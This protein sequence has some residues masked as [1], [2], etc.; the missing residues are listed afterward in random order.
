MPGIQ[1]VTDSA[2]DL[3]PALAEE[4]GV[5]VVPLTIRFG[6]EELVDREELSSKEFWDRVVTGPHMPQT[7]AP[8]PGAFQAVFSEAAES[9]MDG[10][11]CINMSSKVSATIQAAKTAADSVA[12]R[13]PVAVVDS[14]TLTMG[15]GLLVI[16]A[17]GLAASSS[18]L[19]ELLADVEEAASR[20]G[21]RRRRQPRLP[22]QGWPHRRGLSPRGLAPFDQARPRGPRRRR[23]GRLQAAHAHPRRPVLR[24]ESRR[25][26]P[27]RA[28]R[29]GRRPG[30]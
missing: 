24:V 12:D 10:V 7:A 30:I 19:D 6:D 21:L 18:S 13:I 25:C 23:R 8:A 3:P 28:R 14:L 16:E 9:G 29:S 15:L 26:G 1:V 17:V 2:C 20:A 5:R 27:T 22:P 4:L 11:I